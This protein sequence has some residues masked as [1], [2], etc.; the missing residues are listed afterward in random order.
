MSTSFK[1]PF[2]ASLALFILLSGLALASPGALEGEWLEFET[3]DLVVHFWKGDLEREAFNQLNDGRRTYLEILQVLTS[4]LEEYFKEVEQFLKVDYDPAAQGRVYTFVYLT[5]ERYQEAS[6]CLTCAAHVGGFLPA[7]YEEVRVLVK[8]GQ[9]NS[10]A[11]HLTQD[12]KEYVA[13]H[14]FTHLL[15]FSLIDNGPPTFLLEGLATYVGYRLD[16]TPDQWQ[17]GLAEQFVK[18]YLEEYGVGLLEDYFLQAG[19]WKFTYNVGASFLQFLAAQGGWDRFL[20]FYAGLRYPTDHEE[21]DDL[22]REHYRAGLAELVAEWRQ[23]LA[24]VKVTDNA[25]AAYQFKLDQIL[26]RYIFLRPLLRDPWRA[27]RL[28]EEA[29]TLA[30]GQFDQEAGAA[31]REYLSDPHNLR[32]TP[33]AAAEVLEYSRYLLRYVQDYHREEREV[34]GEFVK[35]Y[36]QELPQLYRSKRYEDFAELYF[37]LIHKFVTWR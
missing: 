21:I 10:I 22:C 11:V 12:S 35:Q 18:L 1:R 19:Y 9:A 30:Q 14:E 17:L 25:R 8:E 24:T 5:L 31:L 23:S 28:F 34:V 36:V 37:E 32:P 33:E 3:E 26:H 7:I 16:E 13:L 6:G 27:K 4:E 2:A 29:R 20:E 15:D